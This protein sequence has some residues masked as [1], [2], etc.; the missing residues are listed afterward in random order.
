MSKKPAVATA[1]AAR[2]DGEVIDQLDREILK[3]YLTFNA[4]TS[5]T[6][7]YSDRSSTLAFRLEP[8]EFFPD[9][10]QFSSTPY[11]THTRHGNDDDTLIF[12]IF[13]IV[14]IFVGSL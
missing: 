13:L 14:F 3:S 7:F 9:L 5:K 2:I 8:S 1:I 4:S 6:N 12:L 10:S 11:G